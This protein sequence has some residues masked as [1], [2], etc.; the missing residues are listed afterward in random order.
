[1]LRCFAP[2]IGELLNAINA[3]ADHKLRAYGEALRCGRLL[4]ISGQPRRLNWRKPHPAI[5]T[6]DLARAVRKMISQRKLSRT[7]VALDKLI[8][9]YP[10]HKQVGIKALAKLGLWWDFRP[11]P[12]MAGSAWP[13][14]GESVSRMTDRKTLAPETRRA[15]PYESA[16]LSARSLLKTVSMVVL[17][18]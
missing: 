14:I 1:M 2:S 3:P 10:E 7:V 12:E 15:A 18:L 8:S 16:T 4:Q 11:V 6:G 13:R 17:I 9:K 5:P